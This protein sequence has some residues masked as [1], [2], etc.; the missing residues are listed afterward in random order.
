MAR[1]LI[2]LLG[3]RPLPNILV[4]L[5]FSPDYYR[6]IVSRDS[7][8]IG[9]NYEKAINALPE[10][11]RPPEPPLAVS[12]YSRQETFDKCKEI[13]QQ[14]QDQ[15]AE[16]IITAASEPKM[17]TLGAY[18]FAKARNF[19]MVY[20]ARDGL[21]WVLPKESEPKALEIGLKQ[22][23]QAYGW[24]VKLKGD[25][26]REKFKRL[27]SLLAS[28]LPISHF[29]LHRLRSAGQG[30]GRRTVRVRG[31][32]DEEFELLREIEAIGVVSNVRREDNTTT[33]TINSQ[34]DGEF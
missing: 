6:I 10:K 9:G 2:S 24:D 17:M 7:I 12:P 28:N 21:V 15:E 5:Y 20:V 18:D 26:V 13:V 23:F 30:K 1:V 31:V 4:A 14:Y 32:R 34:E 19:Q 25:N 33:V 16:I 11:L 27:T 3:G 29:L 8:R 22:Y